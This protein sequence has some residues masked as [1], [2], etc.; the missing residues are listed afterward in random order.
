MQSTS[1]LIVGSR[2]VKLNYIDIEK[3]EV[4]DYIKLSCFYFQELCSSGSQNSSHKY[5]VQ[6]NML[7]SYIKPSLAQKILFIGEIIVMFGC[8]PK[9][10]DGK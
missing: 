1:Y 3:E 7:P 5:A 8:D 10:K 6:Y 9:E 2:R 4:E